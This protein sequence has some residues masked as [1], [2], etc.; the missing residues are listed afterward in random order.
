MNRDTMKKLTA[1][2]LLWVI[3]SAGAQNSETNSQVAA[4][5]KLKNDLQRALPSTSLSTG[6]SSKLAADAALLLNNAALRTQGSSLDRTAGRTAA[7]ETGRQSQ[8]GSFQPGDAASL[9]ADLK[10]LQAAAK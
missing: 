10:A 7:E 1:V 6:L 5:S 8:G 4:A 3:K 9:K 2:L